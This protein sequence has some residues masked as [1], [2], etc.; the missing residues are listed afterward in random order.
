[1]VKYVRYRRS[2]R[3]LVSGSGGGGG[4]VVPWN[5]M[6][7]R[8]GGGKILRPR[9][10]AP[11]RT[12]ARVRPNLG[13]SYTRTQTRRKRSNYGQNVPATLQFS[14]VKK[15]WRKQRLG[16]LEKLIGRKTWYSNGTARLTAASGLQGFLD[17][18][19]LWTVADLKNLRDRETTTPAI[20]SSMYLRTGMMRYTIKNQGNMR[21]KLVLYDFLCKK[22]SASA[23]PSFP[24]QWWYQT[25][26]DH[27]QT[28]QYQMVGASPLASTEVMTRFKLMR[29]CCVDLPSGS[30]HQ[31]VVSSNPGR[32]FKSTYLED[33]TGSVYPGYT[34]C[35]L[36]VAY[37]DI[38][39]GP[40]GTG[41]VDATISTFPVKLDVIWNRVLGWSAVSKESEVR[42]YTNNLTAVTDIEAVG[43]ADMTA[44]PDQRV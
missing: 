36:L 42:D 3:R 13:R 39:N 8:G 23:N 9:T 28:T 43:D 22:P 33:V 6:P 17:L 25:G 30:S 40:D 18:P 24:A 14:S 4:W 10:G 15:Y 37:G 35:T 21:V 31:H 19:G 2:R 1:M 38:G 41:T 20:Q 44:R 32:V 26:L 16:Y 5:G 34:V 11:L 27:A 12:G 7:Y 29:R